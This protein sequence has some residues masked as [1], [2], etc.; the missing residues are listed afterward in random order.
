MAYPTVANYKTYGGIVGASEDAAILQILDGTIKTVEKYCNRTFVTN[1]VT[2]NISDRQPWVTLGRR[3]LSFFEDV[4]SITSITN[5][6]GTLLTTA[7]YDLIPIS[8]PPYHQALLRSSSGIRWQVGSDGTRIAVVA[9]F[10]NS[11]TCP[12]DIFL[13]IL[14]LV[15]LSHAGRADGAGTTLLPRGGVIDKA[16]WS[17]RI[18]R[19]LDA[20]RR[21]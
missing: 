5:G 17:E 18:L 19:V 4:A 1:A 6:D 11:A 2:R 8:G 13:V 20:N 16:Q 9:N 14:E 3:M 15:D 10:A 7:D 21:L 12:D